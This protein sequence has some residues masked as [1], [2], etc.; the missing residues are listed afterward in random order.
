MKVVRLS[1]PNTDRFTPQEIFLVLISVRG[2]VD[3]GRVILMKNFNE[4]I[5]NRSR[6]LPV[7][8]A[9]P[10]S[11][12]PRV[13]HF[14]QLRKV[15][16]KVKIQKSHYMPGESLRVPGGWDSQMSRQSAHESG[17]VVSPKCR[18][19]WPPTKYSWYSY[20]LEAQSIAGPECDRKD[21]V[22]ENFQWHD[23]ESNPR[24]SSL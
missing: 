19:P 1:A 18:P 23:R 20:L 4:T 9:V 10:Q 17:K 22:N 7:C 12:R 14:I 11:H 21:Y 8:S 16:V 2:W 13:P 3:I 5:G 15:K 6:Y 24:P